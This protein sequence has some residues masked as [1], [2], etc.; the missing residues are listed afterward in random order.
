M[1]GGERILLHEACGA[2]HALDAAVRAWRG[3]V[4]L[5]E[6]GH[7]AFG[8]D[9][10][11]VGMPQQAVGTV[12]LSRH[13]DEVVHAVAGF[14]VVP[15]FRAHFPAPMEAE[16]LSDRA[17][18]M[19]R[20]GV[21]PVSTTLAIPRP[22]TFVP[23]GEEFAPVVQISPFAVGD[24]AEEPRIPQ[25]QGGEG[26]P[27]V[28]AVFR[29]ETVPLCRFGC[30][31]QGPAF[32]HRGGRGHFHRRMFAAAHRLHRH[33]GVALP[34]GADVDDVQVVQRTHLAPCLFAHKG[35]HPRSAAFR[36]QCIPPLHLL[37]RQRC[38]RTDLRSL[39]IAIATKGLQPALAQ[40]D[41][42]DA[43]KGDGRTAQ[44]VGRT[45]VYRRVCRRICRMRHR[46]DFRLQKYEFPLKKRLPLPLSSFFLHLF[47]TFSRAFLAHLKNYPYFCT[48]FDKQDVTHN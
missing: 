28:A 11:V 8:G 2:A 41:E 46:R 32:V 43:Y 9:E 47:F 19:C 22:C 48:A 3:A 18:A 16:Q 15:G 20:I 21:A 36:Q 31:H 30:A 13:R 10:R 45:R 1:D 34:V 7:T 14:R 24:G 6:D 29:H 40:P 5:Q 25:V 39:H 33:S 27:V 35:A 42:P 4:E 17:D 44:L 38:Q 23:L 12:G 26:K 37:G